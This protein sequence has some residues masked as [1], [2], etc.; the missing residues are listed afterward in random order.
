[1]Y[2]CIYV[3]I[4]VYLYLC[5]ALIVGISNANSHQQKRLARVDDDE[6]VA[7][8]YRLHSGTMP[9]GAIKIFKRH[10]CAKR[11]KRSEGKQNA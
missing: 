7:Q 4:A 10:L 3:S 5:A 6:A 9:A 2:L 11:V 1:M 8:W